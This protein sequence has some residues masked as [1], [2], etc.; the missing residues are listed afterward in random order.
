MLHDY[1]LFWPLHGA[2]SNNEKEE[3]LSGEK[4]ILVDANPKEEVIEHEL[5]G[6]KLIYISSDL[7]ISS[8]KS[9]YYF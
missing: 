6:F 3:N 4:N 9:I 5:T 7:G 1:Y 2:E 8:V